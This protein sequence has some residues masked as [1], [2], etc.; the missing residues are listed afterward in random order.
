MGSALVN[1]SLPSSLSSSLPLSLPLSEAS[2]WHSED[3]L[4]HRV[5][6]S[7][8]VRIEFLWGGDILSLK[9]S[10]FIKYWVKLRHI[11]TE[12]PIGGKDSQES[13]KEN[14]AHL[15]QDEDESENRHLGQVNFLKLTPSRKLW[16]VISSDA[17]GGTVASWSTWV[18]LFVMV[19]PC[20]FLF[21]MSEK[22]TTEL[23]FVKCPKNKRSMS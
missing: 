17:V 23:C 4:I 6:I 9:L 15:T 3:S 10:L 21:F 20:S 11:L 5:N 14:E 13:G 12:F 18:G 2:R 1:P 16:N 22:R 7:L 19:L 8:F